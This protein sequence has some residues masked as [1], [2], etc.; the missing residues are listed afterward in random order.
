MQSYDWYNDT[1]Y[2]N[3]D[4]SSSAI[5]EQFVYDPEILKL[6]NSPKYHIGD[7][8]VESAFIR[9]TPEYIIKK[10]VFVK[11]SF[12]GIPTV[13]GDITEK[14]LIYSPVLNRDSQGITPL[15]KVYNT[16]SINI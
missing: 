9:L 11:N 6:Y 3:W 8:T 1:L 12:L 13:Y 2:N 5:D 7:K 16:S 10:G 14:N 15:A 4:F